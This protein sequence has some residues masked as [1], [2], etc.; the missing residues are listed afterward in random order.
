[1]LAG[2]AAGEAELIE[3]IHEMRILLGGVL[4]PHAAFLLLRGIK[5]LSLRMRAHCENALGLARFL[6]Q[7]P[8]VR[9]VHYPWLEGDPE[10][11]RARA[12][13]QGGGGV[14]SFEVEGGLD[15]ARACLEALELIPV[16][17]SLGGVETLAEI[18]A[19]IDFGSDQVGAAADQTGIAPGL[20]RLAVGIEDLDDLRRD[21]AGGLEALASHLQAAG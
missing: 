2:A 1:M 13:M 20:I 6:S 8:E 15:G 3:R 19:D 10:H 7:R 16:A 14:V 9:R 11:E 5:T 4:D 12:Q 18:P 21:L 17:T